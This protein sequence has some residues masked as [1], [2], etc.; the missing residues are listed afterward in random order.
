M[1]SAPQQVTDRYIG[2]LL[3]N[4]TNKDGFEFHYVRRLKSK[5][6]EAAVHRRLNP[7]VESIELAIGVTPQQALER[8][9]AKFGVTFRP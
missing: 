5:H 2:H 6:Y 1:T 4:G 8:T 7:E 3:R 9:L